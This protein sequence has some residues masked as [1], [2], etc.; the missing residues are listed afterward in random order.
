[1]KQIHQ[2]YKIFK[3]WETYSWYWALSSFHA[4]KVQK[5]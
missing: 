4:L 3:L 5:N 2:T 1:V